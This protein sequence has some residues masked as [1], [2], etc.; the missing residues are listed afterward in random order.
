MDLEK[1]PR[2]KELDALRG[3]AALLVVF[4]HFT[5]NRPQADYG[6]KLGTTGIDL[7]F[8]ISGFVI[9]MSLSKIKSSSDYIINRASR[10]YPA[11]WTAVTFTFILI[12]FSRTYGRNF[13]EAFTFNDYLANLTMFQFYFVLPDLDGPYWTLIIELNFYIGMFFLFHYKKMKYLNAI[14]LSLSCIAVILTSYF[15]S[16]Y[17]VK[18]LIHWVPLLQYIPLFFAG[19]LFYR[20]YKD[21]T[22]LAENYLMIAICFTCQILLFNYAGRSFNFISHSEYALMLILYFTFFILF[23][24]GNLKFIVTSLTMF[25]GR[26]SYPLF[27]SHQF[28]SINILIPFL[29]KK[30]HIN[31]WIASFGIAL[32]ISIVIAYL[33]TKY[34]E[35][36]LGQVMKEKL[37]ALKAWSKRILATN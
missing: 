2:Y 7:F 35:V 18:W 25:F 12:I 3:I 26:I 31:F 14:G 32:P 10:L 27:L 37:R 20:I 13:I 28:L 9:L 21:K 6:F 1:Q 24:N 16:V 19:T 34:I 23:V 8:L 15:Y 22:R 17:E 29:T 4:F 36:P 11:Y 5:M 33:I 30:L